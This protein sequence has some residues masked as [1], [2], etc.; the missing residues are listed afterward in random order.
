MNLPS[1]KFL[2]SYRLTLGFGHSK[3]LGGG[4]K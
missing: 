2:F 3:V 1:F 4:K